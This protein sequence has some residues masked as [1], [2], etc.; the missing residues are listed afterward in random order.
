M[1]GDGTAGGGL[2]AVI[3]VDAGVDHCVGQH[4]TNQIG[5][6]FLQNVLSLFDQLSSRVARASDQQHAVDF[7]GQQRAIGDCHQGWGVEQDD[8]RLFL[9]LC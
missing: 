1:L 3:F 5:F 8:V 7:G 2:V 4:G 6:N 9:E